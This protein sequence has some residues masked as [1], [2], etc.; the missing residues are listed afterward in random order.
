[1]PYPL[2]YY[3]VDALRKFFVSVAI[4]SLEMDTLAPGSN[5]E[6]HSFCGLK[7]FFQ[8]LLPLYVNAYI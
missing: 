5:V 2:C 1:M 6:N 4:C 3:Y 7:H 8:E